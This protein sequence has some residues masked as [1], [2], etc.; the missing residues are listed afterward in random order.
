MELSG[1]GGSAGNDGFSASGAEAG[2]GA[3]FSRRL[4]NGDMGTD[5]VS[6]V[7]SVLG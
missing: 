4:R 5:L 7:Y 1:T 6:L 3:D 2:G